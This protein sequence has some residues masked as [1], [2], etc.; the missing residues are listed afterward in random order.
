MVDAVGVVDQEHDHPGL[1]VVGVVAVVDVVFY[2]H[3]LGTYH[4]VL[5]HQ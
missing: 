1:G 5:D 3:H 2:H 4:G